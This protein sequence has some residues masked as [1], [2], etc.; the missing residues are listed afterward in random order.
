MVLHLACIRPNKYRVVSVAGINV[1]VQACHSWGQILHRLD[2]KMTPAVEK[3]ESPGLTGG[4][5]D[6]AGVDFRLCCVS[7]AL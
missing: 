2:I 6:L 7:G 3:S 4:R 1:Y 5:A